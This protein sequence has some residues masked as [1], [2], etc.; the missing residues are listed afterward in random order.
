MKLL[1]KFL[2]LVS[3]GTFAQHD[4]TIKVK[5]PD[6]KLTPLATVDQAPEF[7]G[8]DRAKTQFLASNVR[9]PQEAMEKGCEGNVYLEFIVETDGSV[10]DLK[11][12][13]N[14]GCAELQ[15]EALRVVKMLKFNPALKDGI[16][17]RA[18]F[19]IPVRFKLR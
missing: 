18:A 8:G 16:P 5:K 15:T 19:K 2:C 10:T 1:V 14:T 12:V 17:V 6:K 3:S 9:Y 7:P 4:A 11:V 13:D